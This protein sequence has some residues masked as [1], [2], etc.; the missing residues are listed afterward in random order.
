MPDGRFR[1]GQVQ[2]PR[3][4]DEDAGVAP[5]DL[6]AGLRQDIGGLGNGSQAVASRTR[7]PGNQDRCRLWRRQG[8]V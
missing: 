8:K 5:A 4:R 6:Q 1:P 2:G 7:G 3:R